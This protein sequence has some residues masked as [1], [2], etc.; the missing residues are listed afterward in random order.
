MAARFDGCFAGVKSEGASITGWIPPVDTSSAGAAAFSLGGRALQ[1][2]NDLLRVPR[3]IDVGAPHPFELHLDPGL[4]ELWAPE[5]PR[6]CVPVGISAVPPVQVAGIEPPAG[7]E[8]RAGK[9]V[10]PQGISE[11]DRPGSDVQDEEPEGY[12]D[13]KHR[14]A[15]RESQQ[16]ENWVVQESQEG[17]AE[18]DEKEPE[19]AER[20]E[21]D[22]GL[23][24]VEI[25][26]RGRVLHL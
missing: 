22:V 18:Y 17:P 5:D 9:T 7:D 26:R 15:E 23:P 11:G 13:K 21:Y 24:L 2:A 4:E 6:A 1:D 8:R 12:R 16:Q 19:S 14:D 20:P 25:P 3:G 10:G